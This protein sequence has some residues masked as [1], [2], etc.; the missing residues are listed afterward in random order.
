MTPAPNAAPSGL[1]ALYAR[2]LHWL[3]IALTWPRRAW[4]NIKWFAQVLAPCR[5]SILFVLGGLVFLL[6]GAGRDV[7]RGLAEKQVGGA[8]VWA[9]F[10][11]FF[12]AFV[13][14]FGAW[15]WSRIM[16]YLRFDGGPKLRETKNLKKVRVWTPRIIGLVAAATIP[17]ALFL[18]TA[19]YLPGAATGARLQHYAFFSLLGAGAFWV[20]AVKR[21]AAARWAS[22][23]LQRRAA[24]A[25]S[26]RNRLA[27]QLAVDDAMK[28][29]YG[30][31][32]LRELPPLAQGILAITVVGELAL[33]ALF[34]TGPER[35]APVFGAAA[36]VLLAFSGWIVLGSFALYLGN[37]LQVPVLSLLII[38][39]V[40]CSFFNDNHAVRTL[41]ATGHA[42][43]PRPDLEGTLSAW[44]EDVG[45]HAPAGRIP[46]YIVAA[47]GGG[48]RAAYWTA[49]VLSR[50][51]D[52]NPH[53][54]DHLF[55][56]SGV[57]GGSLGGAVFTSL[58]AE[59]RRENTGEG[60]F[61]C[62]LGTRQHRSGR[63]RPC[64]QAILA[65]DFLSP[66]V[67]GI[68]YPD[69][70]QRIVP[71]GIPHF[72]RARA[73]EGAWEQAWT[74][75]LKNPRFGA[76]FDELWASP[77]GWVPALFLNTTSVET[78]RRVIVSN[79][80]LRSND[81]R[82][83]F[84]DAEDGNLWIGERMPLSAAV[85]LSARFSYVSPA[86]S[87]YGRDDASPA[88]AKLK[89][90]LVDGGYF[91][92]SG[93]TTAYELLTEIERLKKQGNANAR[94]NALLKRIEPLIILISNDQQGPWIRGGVY[95]DDPLRVTPEVLS[96]VV[97]LINTRTA[98]GTWAQANIRA[99]I[100]RDA[101]VHFA[102]CPAQVAI[103]LGWTLSDLT[104][105]E[106]DQ[107]LDAACGF[108]DNLR[109]ELSVLERLEKSYPKLTVTPR[110]KPAPPLA[111]H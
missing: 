79:I 36:V 83:L 97:T 68:L 16:L 81:G 4:V 14:A 70:V 86:A 22:R 34:L 103:P 98:R 67:A 49:T 31:L 71:Y 40:A 5:F 102:L 3:Y 30:R 72:D 110:A 95:V 45:T 9:A 46:L 94:K 76:A 78:G 20:F 2:L 48:I 93:A 64:A 8:S 50:L 91:E 111:A 100:E 89:G 24:R 88:T 1:S 106:M 51:Q 53:F 57:S 65:Q 59:S 107:Q 12:A 74:Q 66:V 61:V 21:R 6:T 37:R 69:L 23:T 101:S 10:W 47:D 42:Q 26:V 11:F 15:Y 108:I 54:A 28:E 75:V 56:V 41:A 43:D 82:T 73:L 18:A 105:D 92:N 90:H 33:L 39:A 63:L 109:A 32:T 27:M 19:G 60:K 104:E 96:P 80:K 85:H 55:A 58:I 62:D 99:R 87:I 84:G 13:W 44:L 25:N 77:S 52:E 29:R 38:W 17:L 7:L 35:V